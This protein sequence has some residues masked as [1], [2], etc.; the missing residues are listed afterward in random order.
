MGDFASAALTRGITSGF[1]SAS[2]LVLMGSAV[3][4]VVELIGIISMV[5]AGWCC[6]RTATPARKAKAAHRDINKL[7]DMMIVALNIQ[8]LC[9]ESRELGFN[10]TN[11]KILL[12]AM[13]M[14][15]FVVDETDRNQ[16]QSSCV[17]VWERRKPSYVSI[18]ITLKV[19]EKKTLV[20]G[21]LRILSSRQ[22]DIVGH[23]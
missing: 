5:V 1:V 15:I 11:F 6:C 19:D 23:R 20:K 16:S 4:V 2:A 8:F 14:M 7:A 12:L 21:C 3:V 18:Q 17:K 22:R 13:L 10:I 9:C